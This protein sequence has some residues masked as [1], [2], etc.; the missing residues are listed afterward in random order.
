MDEEMQDYEY[1]TVAGLI[2]NELEHVPEPGECV[3][4]GCF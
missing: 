2:L 4:W 1:T 3:E